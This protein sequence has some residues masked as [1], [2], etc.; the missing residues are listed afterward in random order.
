MLRSP[1]HIKIIFTNVLTSAQILQL[2]QKNE[3]AHCAKTFSPLQNYRG[4]KARNECFALFISSEIH[5]N[6]GRQTAQGHRL[7]LPQPTAVVGDGEALHDLNEAHADQ[8]DD[9]RPPV[10][11]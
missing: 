5:N 3:L 9:R 6:S 4:P 1:A 11:L 7:N 8:Q 10:I 2:S